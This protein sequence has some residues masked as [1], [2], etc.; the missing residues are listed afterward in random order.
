MDKQLM[1]SAFTQ[2]AP[3]LTESE[4]ENERDEHHQS[5]GEK[6]TLAL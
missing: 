6:C 4:K 5:P 3:Y 2:H 1:Q